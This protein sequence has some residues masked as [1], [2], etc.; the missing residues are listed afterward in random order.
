MHHDE[1]V[2][3]QE[4]EQTERHCGGQHASPALGIPLHGLER[5]VD[6]GRVGSPGLDP[7]PGAL[8]PLAQV[9]H[10]LPHRLTESGRSRPIGWTRGQRRRRSPG[11]SAVATPHSSP[12]ARTE[13]RSPPLALPSLRIPPCGRARAMGE[14]LPWVPSLRSHSSWPAVCK[15]QA[16]PASSGRVR[17][18]VGAYYYLWNPGELR[19]RNTAVPPRAAATARRLSRQLL[20]PAHGRPGHHQRPEGGNQLLRRGLVALRPWLLRRGLPAG[21]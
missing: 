5:R 9:L 16:S 2:G 12:T 20:E 8:R 4:H 13:K 18:L 17:P 7:R 19:R 3:H 14:M 21:R 10:A 6:G 1:G 11:S 15:R